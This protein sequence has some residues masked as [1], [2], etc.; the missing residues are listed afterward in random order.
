MKIIKTIPNLDDNTI[1]RIFVN[2]QRILLK[3]KNNADANNVLDAI[4]IEWDKR[5]KLFQI[6]KYKAASPEQGI[7]SVVG[8]KVGNNGEKLEIRHQML[9]YIMSDILPPVSS[10]AYMAEWGEKLSS[11]RY[12]KLHRVIK[13]LASSGETIGNMDKA[14]NEWKTDL[15]YLE[16]TWR[17]RIYS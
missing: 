4:K 11:T 8:Y 2:T 10:P 1:C 16:N 7:L 6:G 3:D 9:D 12:R 17:P 5:L 13:V 14:V 15:N